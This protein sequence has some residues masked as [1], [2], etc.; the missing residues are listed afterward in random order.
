MHENPAASGSV[1][2]GSQCAQVR[3]EHVRTTGTVEAYDWPSTT[4]ENGWD[5]EPCVC[6]HIL[7]K[8]NF[9]VG[10]SL[11]DLVRSN[12]LIDFD[13]CWVEVG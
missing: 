12:R 10:G 8:L 4:P 11:G 6:G 5:D 13:P 1:T 2:S 7:L 9:S 3:A